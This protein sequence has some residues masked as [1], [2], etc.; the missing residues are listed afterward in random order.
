MFES[1]QDALAVVEGLSEPSKMPCYG[2]SL[3]RSACQMGMLM[4]AR[5]PEGICGKCYAKL[6]N[7]TFKHVQ[8]AMNRRLQAIQ[9]PRWV[10]HQSKRRS[11]A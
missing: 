11:H 3:P 6:G 1:R 4:A 5:N 8:A 7:Y 10:D 9:E 2:Y